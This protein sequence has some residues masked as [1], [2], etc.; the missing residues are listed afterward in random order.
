MRNLKLLLLFLSLFVAS[1]SIN[2]DNKAEQNTNESN[3]SVEKAEKPE[4][5]DDEKK[6]EK[7]L[8]PDDEKEKSSST[9]TVCTNL[10]R[11]GMKLDKKQTF[12]VEFKPFENSCFATFHEHDFEDPPLGEKF[13]IYKDG[14]E[15]YEFPEQTEAATYTIEGIAFEDLNDDNLTDVIVVGSIGL[16]FGTV[17]SSQVYANNGRD[18]DTN[19][20]ANMKLDDFTKISEIK[21]FVKKNQKLFFP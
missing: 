14:K 8:F 20:D 15:V 4:K 16:K 1:C 11:D 7:P 18:F 21:N 17:Y 6:S 19:S 3:K 12:P 13:Y 2:F 5:S 9:K 10:K